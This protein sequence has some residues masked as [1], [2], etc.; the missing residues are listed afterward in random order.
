MTCFFGFTFQASPPCKHS[1]PQPQL[2]YSSER[3]WLK[4]KKGNTPI[5]YK[6]NL[7]LKGR[8]EVYQSLRTNT[9]ISSPPSFLQGI[10]APWY[11]PF[12]ILIAHLIIAYSCPLLSLTSLAQTLVLS[13]KNCFS[14]FLVLLI[15][16]IIFN[17]FGS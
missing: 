6:L 16:W 7:W 11:T 5:T 3:L 8:E 12:Q 10:N 15:F 4:A 17:G 2:N 9:K 1:P 14:F 13:I